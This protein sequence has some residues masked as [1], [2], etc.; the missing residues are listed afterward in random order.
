M[1]EG[2]FSIIF[3]HVVPGVVE[4]I[5]FCSSSQVSPGLGDAEIPVGRDVRKKIQ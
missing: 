3:S 5:E 1:V 2:E 4:V